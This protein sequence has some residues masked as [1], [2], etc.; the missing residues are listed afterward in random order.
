[1]FDV[2]LHMCNVQSH[3]LQSHRCMSNVQSHRGMCLFHQVK[4]KGFTRVH[5]LNNVNRALQILQKNNVSTNNNYLTF[6]LCFL[7]VMYAM[8]FFFLHV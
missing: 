8:L 6:F 7:D 4:E 5:S 3:R 2:L 1:M